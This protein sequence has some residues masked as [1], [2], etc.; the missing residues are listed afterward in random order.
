MARPPAWT[1]ILRAACDEAVLAVRLYNDPAEARAF[2]GFVVHM[3]VAWLYLLQARFARDG[4]D[5]RYRRRDNPRWFVRVDGEIKTWELAQCIE[6][7]WPDADDA[8]RKNLEFF[9][10]LRNKIEHRH[11][12]QDRS[13]GMSV[14]GHAQAHVLNFEHELTSTFG[15]KYSLATM[16]RFPVFIGTFTTEGTEALVKLRRQLPADL[17]RYIA[18]FHSGLDDATAGD[19]RFELR[20]KVVLEQIQR[21]DEDSMAIEFVRWGDLTDEERSVVSSLGRQGKT[22]VREQKRS[23]VGHGLLRPSEAEQRVAAAIP[24]RFNSYDFLQAWKRKGVRPERGTKHPERTDE[25]YCVYDELSNQYGYTQAWVKWLIKS[26]ST[27]K[28]FR[29]A[30]GREPRPKV[31]ADPPSKST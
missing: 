3:H 29:A 1:A 16:L 28:G 31:E 8:V 20:L 26:C 17:R 10:G 9:V 13:L 11:S 14:S 4:V 2:E 18:E 5:Y 27:A 21:P 22:I 12:V 7:R 19:D 15:S 25:K 23:V 6:E 24:Y 30:T